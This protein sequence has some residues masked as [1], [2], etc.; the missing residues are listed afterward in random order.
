MSVEDVRLLERYTS[1]IP[2][3]DELQEI[4]FSHLLGMT[5]YANFTTK[6]GEKFKIEEYIPWA[7]D[8]I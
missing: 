6:K 3:G 1:T 4:L 2:S 5:F 8:R 7:K